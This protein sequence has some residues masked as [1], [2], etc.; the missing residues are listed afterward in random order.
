MTPAPVQ[1][2]SGKSADYG[3]QYYVIKSS[4]SPAVQSGARPRTQ[5][6]SKSRVQ[7]ARRTSEWVL[8]TTQ[9]ELI[10]PEESTIFELHP[11]NSATPSRTVHYTPNQP[12]HV[13]PLH[14]PSPEPLDNDWL[15]ELL[16]P[17]AEETEIFKL[18]RSD[19]P[20]FNTS[21][22]GLMQPAD[23]IP[24]VQLPPTPGLSLSDPRLMCR[25]SGSTKATLYAEN[26]PVHQQTE[27]SAPRD[28]IGVDL[29]SEFLESVDLKTYVDNDQAVAQF[30]SS[31]L[32]EEPDTKKS[33]FPPNVICTSGTFSSSD[34]IPE[35]DVEIS[36]LDLASAIAID[37]ILAR[38]SKDLTAYTDA[39]NKLAAATNEQKTGPSSGS[40]DRSRYTHTC[41]YT[42]TASYAPQCTDST[43]SDH[44]SERAQ[45]TSTS[46]NAV[47]TV[48]P[49]H[50]CG[51][52][53]WPACDQP[54]ARTSDHGQKKQV[55]MFH[56]TV[57]KSTTAARPC[58][59]DFK[60]AQTTTARQVSEVTRP[61]EGELDCRLQLNYKVYI[62]QTIIMASLHVHGFS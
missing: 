45:Y 39:K 61:N 32:Y 7:A 10:A 55:D 33:K 57:G 11:T 48:S 46:V 50:S 9:P 35:D 56:N 52:S 17:H 4:G 13:N 5:P 51:S 6:I 24:K 53:T 42:S 59:A 21:S 41:V 30:E 1:Y 29:D 44:S 18:E 34:R 19:V 28:V 62:Q 38:I 23:K 20:S 2:L 47:C 49:A 16:S 25:T 8:S 3:T 12:T 22:S 31:L 37:G 58:S 27:N 60:M 40:F 43:P 14:P 15:S 36:S 54:A 26:I